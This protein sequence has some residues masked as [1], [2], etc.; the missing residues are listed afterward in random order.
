MGRLMGDTSQAARTSAAEHEDDLSPAK[1][2]R[3]RATE[4]P[5]QR[6][7]DNIAVANPVTSFPEDE[8]SE[9]GR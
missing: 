8:S 1:I 5:S 6:V 2:V 7:G 4:G 9:R 3:A